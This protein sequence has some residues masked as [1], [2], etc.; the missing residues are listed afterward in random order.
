MYIS[1]PP[2]VRFSHR[3]LARTARRL[4]RCSC[5][6]LRRLWH[7]LKWLCYKERTRQERTLEILLSSVPEKHWPAALDALAREQQ[8]GLSERSNPGAGY[9]TIAPSSEQHPGDIP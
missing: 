8:P 4:R 1:Q 7:G 3:C 5:R 6:W 9:G 2:P